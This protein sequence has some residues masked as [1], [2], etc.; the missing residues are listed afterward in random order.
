MLKNAHLLDVTSA[1]G[2][3]LQPPTL[4]FIANVNDTHTE[5]RLNLHHAEFILGGNST[6]FIIFQ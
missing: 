3:N 1:N 4:P 5:D 2:F 6:F